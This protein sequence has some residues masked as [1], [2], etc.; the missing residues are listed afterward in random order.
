MSKTIILAMPPVMGIEQAIIRNLKFHGF[1]VIEIIYQEPKYRYPSLWAMLKK[2][3]HYTL[4]KNKNYRK[5]LRFSVVKPE[6]EDKLNRIDKKADYCLCLWPAHFPNSLMQMMRDKAE[7]MVHY[8]WESLDFFKEDFDKLPYFDHF[9]FFDPKDM[10]RYPEYGFKPITSFYF[11]DDTE[12]ESNNS[13]FFLGSY[14]PNRVEDIRSFHAAAEKTGLPIDFQLAC[15]NPETVQ[16]ELNLTGVHCFSSHHAVPY[17]KYLEMAK[18]AGVLI[19]FLNTK[20]YGLSLRTFEAIGFRKKLITTNPT[21]VHYDFYHPDNILVWTGNNHQQLIDF[22]NT[23]YVE[24]PEHIRKKYG[25]KNWLDFV[26]DRPP[27][28]AIHLPSI[29]T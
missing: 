21:V 28:Q 16:Q 5:E 15:P 24:L 25:F 6:F 29:N 18:Q 3:F 4:L 22:L 12:T 9:Y 2:F 23:P 13:L 27:Y 14:S 8:N 7:V 11:D 10:G 26:F 19:D 17:P 20:H 1:E